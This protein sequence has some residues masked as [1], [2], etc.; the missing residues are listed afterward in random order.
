MPRRRSGDPVASAPTLRRNTPGPLP[1]G[2]LRAYRGA[3]A[4][5]LTDRDRYLRSIPERDVQ[6]TI[7]RT[8]RATRWRIMRVS[9]SRKPVRRDGR[10]TLVGDELCAGWPDIF[11]CRPPRTFAIECKTETGKLTV[12]QQEWL[13]DLR[14]SGIEIAVARPSTLDEIIQ[15]LH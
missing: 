7:L 11:L 4:A 12:A 15:R 13:R 1:P 10:V 14:A 9:D 3:M 2:V 5:R 6:D 8:A